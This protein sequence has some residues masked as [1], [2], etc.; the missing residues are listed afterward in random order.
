MTAWSRAPE[1]GAA[2][3]VHLMLWLLRH[4]RPFARFVVLP[5]ITAWF[6]AFSAPARAASREFLRAALGRPATTL[7]VLRH[8]H[9]FANAILDRATMLTAG[10]GAINLDV[11]GLAHVEA[12]IAAG[13]G[14]LLFGAHLGS[15]AVLRQLAEQ[16]PVPVKVLMWQANAGAYTRAMQVLDP[17]AAADVIPIGGVQSMLRVQ[18]AIDAGAIVGVLADRAPEGA[19]RIDVPFFDRPAPFPIGPFVL[20]ASLGAPVLLFHG[21]RVGPGRYRVGFTPFADRIALRR[22]ARDADLRAVI[23]RYAAWLEGTCRSY[24]FN[25]FNFFPFWERAEHAPTQARPLVAAERPGGRA[26]LGANAA[27]GLGP[28]AG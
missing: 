20:A 2:W 16:C 26:V 14:C 5:G 22:G 28:A 13:R 24:P 4:A 23:A 11:T 9:S 27:T 1:R 6:F 17:A 10:P 7:D 21:A 15:F 8:I 3:L 18:E 12:A 19:R 25:W